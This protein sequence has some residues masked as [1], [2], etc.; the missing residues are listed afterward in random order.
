MRNSNKKETLEMCWG[1]RMCVRFC[2][3]MGNLGCGNRIALLLHMANERHNDP[4][5][6]SNQLFTGN[7]DK[8]CVIH[9]S[10]EF[11]GKVMSITC[12]S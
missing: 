11:P 6:I 10:D 2:V 8:L 4:G 9:T 1:T 12:T 7:T 5:F 3:M